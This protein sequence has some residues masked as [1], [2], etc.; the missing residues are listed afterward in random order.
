MLGELVRRHVRQ[1]HPANAKM[2]RRALAFG[3]ERIRRLL[4]TVVEERIGALEAE[5]QPR[6]GGLPERRVVLLF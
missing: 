3:D 5:D 2:W 4:N 6:P 1:Q